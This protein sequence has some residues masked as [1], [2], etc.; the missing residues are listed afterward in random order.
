ML[1]VIVDAHSNWL[2]IHKTSSASTAVTVDKCR[3]SHA[4]FG[5]PANIVSDNAPYISCPEF[6][7]FSTMNIIKQVISPPRSPKSNRLM[8]GAV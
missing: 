1:L 6:Q 4:T 3:L 8:E 2:D 7:S 5:I